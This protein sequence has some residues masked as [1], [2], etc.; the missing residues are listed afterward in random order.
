MNIKS[1]VE[2]V[3]EASNWCLNDAP[4]A[5]HAVGKVVLMLLAG[6]CMKTT[7]NKKNGDRHVHTR[8]LPLNLAG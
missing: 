1:S 3:L 6:A 5:V 7:V 4:Q 2:S 8:M